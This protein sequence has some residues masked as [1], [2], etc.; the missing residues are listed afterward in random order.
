MSENSLD[1]LSHHNTHQVTVHHLTK[2]TNGYKPVKSAL[3]I[4]VQLHH[5]SLY[6]IHAPFTPFLPF[7]QLPLLLAPSVQRP[8]ERP[9]VGNLQT[10]TAQSPIT[11][12]SSPISQF[13]ASSSG[14]NTPSHGK[15]IIHSTASAV[16]PKS[17]G[18]IAVANIAK[19]MRNCRSRSFEVGNCKV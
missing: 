8:N 7:R 6:P 2:A 10:T 4:H 5:P 9:A 13:R 17:P 11:S 12:N 3:C 19:K 16:R 14:Y 1:Y 18:T 15:G